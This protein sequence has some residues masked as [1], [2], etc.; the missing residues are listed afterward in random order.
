MKKQATVTQTPKTATQTP[1]VTA[2]ATATANPIATPGDS[3][4]TGD[5]SGVRLYRTGTDGV[6]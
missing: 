4:Y 3:Q 5:D 2:T 1:V 6:R